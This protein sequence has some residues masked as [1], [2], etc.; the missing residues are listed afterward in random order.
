M[1]SKKSFCNIS[2]VLVKRN[3]KQFWLIPIV[4]FLAYFIKGILPLIVKSADTQEL[5]FFAENVLVNHD[6]VY[7][8]MLMILPICAAVAV[9][10]YLHGNASATMIHVMP[11][12]R[13]KLYRSSVLSGIILFTLPI[14]LTA[15]CFAILLHDDPYYLG[16]E[17]L[18]KWIVQTLISAFYIYAVSIM[19]AM[20]AGSVVTHI[21]L[22]L[23]F[24]GLLP[25]MVYIINSFMR[26]FLYGFTNA[27]IASSIFSP[28]SQV[29]INYGIS[30]YSSS[31]IIFYLF[32]IF[33]S[34]ILIWGSGIAYKRV[35]LENEGNAT[36]FPLLGEIIC[37]LF[38]FIATCGLGYIIIRS[39]GRNA[40]M[41]LF[42]TASLVSSFLFYVLARMILEKAF[43]VFRMKMFKKY[44]LLLAAVAIFFSLTVFDITGYSKK[45]PDAKS[46]EYVQFSD[47][48]VGIGM[49][50][51]SS[52][53]HLKE[54]TSIENFTA[55]HHQLIEHQD[56]QTHDDEILNTMSISYHLKDGKVLERRYDVAFIRNEDLIQSY[57]KIF[58]SEEY[59]K[60]LLA[61][62]GLEIHSSNLSLQNWEENKVIRQLPDSFVSEFNEALKKDI[63]EMTLW[64]VLK[65]QENTGKYTLKYTNLNGDHLTFYIYSPYKNV[66]NLLTEKYHIP[67]SALRKD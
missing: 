3:L 38:A 34:V 49:N 6:Y 4:A 2:P 45:V 36:V 18:P 39:E 11:F 54:K 32:Y 19:A 65:E 56:D 50:D 66:I 48:F 31:A 12:T 64:D 67:P 15:I 10:S 14:L 42:L 21:L 25:I 57:G 35:P 9:F 24:N 55:F 28:I 63:E 62:H 13:K 29:Y 20:V 52:D 58:K 33:V 7:F 44:L 16:T 59:Q 26:V 60:L 22:S 47:S 41:P 8:A 23:F 1:T 37:Y 40:G 53:S 27:P 61:R 30:T 46:I 5:R 51:G 17:I 43:H